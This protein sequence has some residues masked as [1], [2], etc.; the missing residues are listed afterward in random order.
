MKMKNN[1][2]ACVEGKI[3]TLGQT[4]V[5]TKLLYHSE[6][7]EPTTYDNVCSF[8][9]LTCFGHQYAHHQEYKM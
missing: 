9:A 2:H 4:V 5:S 8:I 3:V 7:K 6:G 1:G